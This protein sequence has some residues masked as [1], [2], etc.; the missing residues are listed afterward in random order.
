[1]CTWCIY[2]CLQKCLEA[3]TQSRAN[4]GKFIYLYSILDS[5][6]HLYALATG[7]IMELIFNY[8]LII[9]QHEETNIFITNTTIGD[10][11]SGFESGFDTQ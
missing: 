5:F 6:V 3:L 8:Q 9:N 10:M 11:Q 2:T 7:T 4:E 1:M